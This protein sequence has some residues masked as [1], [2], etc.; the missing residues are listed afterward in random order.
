MTQDAGLGE[1]SDRVEG[2]TDQWPAISHHIRHQGQ[3]TDV[4]F[5]KVDHGVGDLPL[6]GQ[7]HFTDVDDLHGAMLVGIAPSCCHRVKAR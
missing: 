5:G 2:Q 6:Q 7:R 1:S 4:V 3:Q